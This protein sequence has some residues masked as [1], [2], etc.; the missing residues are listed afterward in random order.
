MNTEAKV[1]AT[2]LAGLALLAGMIIYLS[3][4]SFGDKGYPVHALFGQVSGLK[5]GNIVRYAG[6]D[7]GTVAAVRVLPDGVMADIMLKPGVKVPIG[8]SFVIGSDGL[9]GE[10]FVNILPPRNVTGFLAPNDQVYGE[11]PQGMDE[12][13]AAANQVL[14]EVKLLVQSLNDVIGDEKVRAALK[15]ITFN[16]RDITD[17]LNRLAA[18]LALMADENHSDINAMVSNLKDMSV[19]LKSTAVRVDSML[20]AV[21]NNGQ[22]A[23]ELRETITALRQTSIR[24]E[25]MA[26]ALEG[27]VTDPETANNLKETLRNARSAS[28]KANQMLDKVANIKT[29]ASIESLYDPDDHTYQNNANVTINTSPGDFA[30]IG[31]NDIGEDNKVNLQFGKSMANINQRLGIIDGKIGVGVDAKLSKDLQMS[32]DAYDPNDVRVK[33]RTQYQ[34][35]P[36]TFLIGQASSLNRREERASFFGVRRSF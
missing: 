21:D 32:L 17:N 5:P 6:V 11:S 22:T 7:V 30:V 14:A 24:V 19:S 3:G 18:T 34:L 23:R 26:A 20:A 9:L 2:T 4:I 8:S 25:K 31:V 35:A 36:D 1:G 16:T 10:K 15:Q 28:T 13:I 29:E 27:V 33:L 12:L